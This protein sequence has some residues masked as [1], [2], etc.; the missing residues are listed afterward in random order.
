MEYVQCLRSTWG[1]DAFWRCQDKSKVFYACYERERV[2]SVPCAPSRRTRVRCSTR[3]RSVS[4]LTS[5]WVRRPGGLYV[6][7]QSGVCQWL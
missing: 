3:G 4:V 1:I 6:G 2:R 7:H 5:D